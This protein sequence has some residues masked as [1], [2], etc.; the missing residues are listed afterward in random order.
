[1]ATIS[2]GNRTHQGQPGHAGRPP[3]KPPGL[4]KPI[5]SPQSKE[6]NK[7]NPMPRFR[8]RLVPVSASRLT[9]DR[10]RQI[11]TDA[12]RPVHFFAGRTIGL[13]WQPAVREEIAWEIF[14]GRLLEPAHTRL[15]QQFEAWHLFRLR[16]DGR[17]AEPLLSVRFDA[18]NKLIHVTRAIYCYVTE[19][20]DAGGQVFL[21]RETRKWVRELVGTI[22]LGPFAE[23]EPLRDELICRLF[24]GVIGTSRLPLTSVEA[25]LS[26]FSLGELAYCYRSH[27]GAD[28]GPMRSYHD[29]LDKAWGDDLAG[30]ERI[31]L[32]ETLLRAT[33][34]GELGDA[35]ARF[36]KRLQTLG[37]AVDI[38]QLLRGLF[39][40]VALSPYTD[41]VTQT[42]GFLEFLVQEGGLSVE[43]HVDF[44]GYLLRQLGRHLSAYDLVTFHHRGAN[45]PDAWLLDAALR[46]YLNLIERAP[47]LF[48]PTVGDT[49]AQTDRKRLRRRALRQAW[50]FRR[51]YEGHLVPD[52][53]T[54]PGDNRRIHPP[55]HLRV[56]DEQI[57]DSTKR[58]RQLFDNDPL[59]AHLGAAGN[60]VL[61]H[62]ILDLQYPHELRELGMALFLDRPLGVFK[63][64][65]ELDQT[66]LLSYEMFSRSL[67]QRRLRELAEQWELIANPM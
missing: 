23:E 54:S 44:L 49:A 46:A 32:L 8:T 7:G 55:P 65:S 19:G 42:L 62:S 60:E 63:R 17:S 21:S 3:E 1:L 14:Q 50:Y 38:P 26:D 36:V 61:R 9:P 13:E 47:L 12:F 31:K 45:Y 53:P 41:F 20:Y 48:K 40:N 30:S 34:P 4:T 39:D 29:L 6:R 64:P 58:T 57:I 11:I 27:P 10:V 66:P 35:T 52:A 43:G 51:H 5:Q 56:P 22:D 37:R 25:P 15:R 18:A 67:A 28:E 59:P 16:S 33:P 2:I 24:Q